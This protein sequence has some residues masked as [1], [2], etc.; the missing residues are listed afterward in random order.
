MYGAA[1][2]ERSPV[3]RERLTW[4]AIRPKQSKNFPAEMTNQ[5]FSL[6]DILKR[7]YE[8]KLG[9]QQIIT[10]DFAEYFMSERGHVP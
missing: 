10:K 7:F 2:R 1:C 8:N 3:H 5:N 6:L 4:Y 9:R